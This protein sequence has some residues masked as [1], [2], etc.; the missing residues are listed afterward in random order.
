LIWFRLPFLPRSLVISGKVIIWV[1]MGRRIWRLLPPLSAP[2]APT[3]DKGL[4]Q[5]PCRPGWGP[6]LGQLGT[7]VQGAR[8]GLSRLPF[9]SL[10]LLI[11]VSSNDLMDQ[12]YVK[13]AT[14][15]RDKMAS[16][17][18]SSPIFFSGTSDLIS[19]VPP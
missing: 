10:Y 18:S 1:K 5:N 2:F 7:L 13:A 4:I 15:L 16:P 19:I 11:S 17:L 8:F 14:R 9:P 12:T 6:N 3:L